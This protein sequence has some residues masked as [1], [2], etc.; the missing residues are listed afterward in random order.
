MLKRHRKM[1]CFGLR[2]GASVTVAGCY[3]RMARSALLS[4]YTRSKFA[5]QHVDTLELGAK[6]RELS[7]VPQLLVSVIH[8]LI[9]TTTPL[10][11]SGRQHSNRQHDFTHSAPSGHERKIKHHHLPNRPPHP[12]QRRHGGHLS[13]LQQRSREL[14]DAVRQDLRSDGRRGREIQRGQWGEQL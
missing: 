1:L 8:S 2:E 6:R 14:Q 7:L 11:H 12:P 4:R 13:H 10:P 3:D 9:L 5:T